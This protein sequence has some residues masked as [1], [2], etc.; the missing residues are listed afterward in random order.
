MALMKTSNPALSERTFQNMSQ[1]QYGTRYGG[2]PGEVTSRMTLNGTV[3]KTANAALPVAPA[4]V[5]FPSQALES[6]AETV[7]AQ[8]W[9]SKVG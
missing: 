6:A 4:N 3:N 9:A 1:S 8:Q 2:Y 5:S 7:V